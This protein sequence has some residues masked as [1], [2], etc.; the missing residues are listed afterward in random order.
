MPSGRLVRLMVSPQVPLPALAFITL[1]HHGQLPTMLTAFRAALTEAGE[2]PAP[3]KRAR[4]KLSRRR[5]PAA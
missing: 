1:V 5:P 4:G 3:I 2:M